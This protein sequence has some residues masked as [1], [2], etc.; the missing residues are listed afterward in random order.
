MTTAAQPPVNEKFAFSS[1]VASDVWHLKENAKGYEWW[2]FDALSDDGRDGI[3]IIFL[4]NFIGSELRPEVLLIYALA[5]EE[6][7]THLSR[8]ALRRP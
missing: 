2:Y 6:S 1:C 4:D 3:V 7:A 8:D 5:A